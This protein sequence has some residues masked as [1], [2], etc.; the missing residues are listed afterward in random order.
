MAKQVTYS[1]PKGYF[2]KEAM[3]LIKKH[4]AEMSKGTGTKKTVKRTTKK[5]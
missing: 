3:A 4:N 1:E 2:S 5:K